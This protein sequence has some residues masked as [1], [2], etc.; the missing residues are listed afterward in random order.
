M[1]DT[2]QIVEVLCCVEFTESKIPLL[3]TPPQENGHISRLST[4]DITGNKQTRNIQATSFNLIPKSL[5]L[6][7]GAMKIIFSGL[8]SWTITN[9]ATS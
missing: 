9:F 3:T 5:C 4:G 8:G 1:H 2:L 7:G 6:V